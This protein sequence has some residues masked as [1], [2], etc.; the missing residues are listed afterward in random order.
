MHEDKGT[1][2][3]DFKLVEL[4]TVLEPRVRWIGRPDEFDKVCHHVA[5]DLILAE[6]LRNRSS[7]FVGSFGPSTFSNLQ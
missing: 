2:I 3:S 6:Y 7:I 1:A 4:V 5:S